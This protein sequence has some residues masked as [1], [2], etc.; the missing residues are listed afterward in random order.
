[1]T[2]TLIRLGDLPLRDDTGKPPDPLVEFDVKYAHDGKIKSETY[3][4]TCNPRMYESFRFKVPV[5]DLCNQMLIFKVTDMMQ[6]N[7][8][9]PPPPSKPEDNKKKKG[10]KKKKE[11][12]PPSLPPPP[13]PTLIGFVMVPLV[14]VAMKKLLSDTEITILRD[15]INLKPRSSSS[16]GS[17][18]MESTTGTGTDDFEDTLETV[19]DDEKKVEETEKDEEVAV[20]DQ[21]Y[22]S[23]VTTID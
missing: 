21:P 12:E 2:L 13:P 6:T 5:N 16:T 11:N 4:T 15:V 19:Q 8:P 9:E 10:N 1:M 20:D 3:Q 22:S 7:I 14:T 23:Q 17:E 18:T